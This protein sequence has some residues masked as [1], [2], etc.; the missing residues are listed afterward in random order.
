MDCLR[1]GTVFHYGL[2]TNPRIRSTGN[3]EESQ[4]T[5]GYDMRAWDYDHPMWSTAQ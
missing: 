3:S 5:T 2:G 4:T 1:Y